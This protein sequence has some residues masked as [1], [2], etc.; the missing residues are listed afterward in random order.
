[1]L[2]PPN[3]IILLLTERWPKLLF[4]LGRRR[5]TLAAYCHA[6]HHYFAF[7]RKQ[8]IEPEKAWLED[9]AAYINPQLPVC[10]FPPLAPRSSS[11]CNSP[12][13]RR[14]SDVSG[15]LYRQS[16][17]VDVIRRLNATSPAPTG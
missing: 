3:E 5:A 17:V 7:C 4:N 11:V 14:C 10:F 2:I 13:V 6:L 9:Q 8:R 15:S 1:M 12:L 16:A